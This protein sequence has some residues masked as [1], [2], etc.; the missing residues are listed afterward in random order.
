[1]AE[2]PKPAAAGGRTHCV[3]RVH[4]ELPQSQSPADMWVL[5]KLSFMIRKRVRV[6]ACSTKLIIR[7]E[8]LRRMKDREEKSGVREEVELWKWDFWW[9]GSGLRGWKGGNSISDEE[10]NSAWKAYLQGS[11]VDADQQAFQQAQHRLGC[12]S[13]SQLIVQSCWA[14]LS[15]LYL[16][17]SSLPWLIIGVA[18]FLDECEDYSWALQPTVLYVTD[19]LNNYLDWWSVF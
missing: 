15:W 7:R 3:V 6:W 8:A 4:Q 5:L 12:E 14:V 18:Y 11:R 1:M 9:I 2:K 10:S 17:P 19:L 16:M 13:F